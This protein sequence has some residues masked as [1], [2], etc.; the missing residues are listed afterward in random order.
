MYSVGMY[1]PVNAFKG[2]MRKHNGKTV[3]QLSKDTEFLSGALLPPTS[4]TDS[5]SSSLQVSDVI[6]MVHMSR[7]SSVAPKH[8]YGILLCPAVRTTVVIS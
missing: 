1:T 7:V 6:S 3:K 4:G 5:S 8:R 2:H